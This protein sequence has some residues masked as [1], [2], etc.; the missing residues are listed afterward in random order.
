[1]HI[2][3]VEPQ[4]PQNSG[5]IGRLCAGLDLELHL[6]KPLGFSLEDKYLKR[7]GLDYWPSIRLTVHE[8]F[9]ALLAAFPESPVWLFTARGTRSFWDVRYGPDDL[10]IFGREADGL[11]PSVIS[12]FPDR[13]L[14][15]PHNTKIRSLNLAN[16]VSVVAYEAQ[17]QALA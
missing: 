7:A 12:R 5:N 2:V 14:T 9:H 3:L 10:L 13:Q 16:A 11:P 15:V 6:V 8:S 4:I 17:R 1:M